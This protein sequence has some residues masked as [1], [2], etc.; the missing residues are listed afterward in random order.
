MFRVN[1]TPPGLLKRVEITPVI[2]VIS[3]TV[4]L[5]SQKCLNW[6]V[7]FYHYHS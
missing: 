5:H 7:K 4:Y 3:D 1:R 2:S 6:D